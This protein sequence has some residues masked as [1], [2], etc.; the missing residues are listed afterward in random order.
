MATVD[1]KNLKG[2]VTGQIELSDAIFGLAEPNEAVM[3]QV[4]KAI[5]ANKR[6]GTAAT[7]T[8]S[9]T[10]G[11]GRRPYRQ[12]GTG[13]ARQ[14]SI[15]AA[16][17]VGGGVIFGPQPRSYRQSVTKKM[18]RLAMKS[19][20]SCKVRDGQLIVVEDLALPEV[21]TKNFVEAMKA[22]NVPSTV[23]VVDADENKNLFL[24]ARNVADVQLSRVNTL[25]VYDILNN[26]CLLLTKSAV[27]K[28][29]EVYAK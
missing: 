13:R 11:G 16:Q 10:R 25:N 5:L 15:R 4:V 18:R 24:S 2:A 14:G 3:H 7:R 8:R 29:E 27:A 12:K 23:L 28:I 21:K 1:V 20:F 26:E 17:W 22:L 6:Q 19:A 9:N